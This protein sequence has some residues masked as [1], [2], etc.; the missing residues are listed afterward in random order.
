MAYQLHILPAEAFRNDAA[1]RLAVEETDDVRVSGKPAAVTHASDVE[2]KIAGSDLGAEIFYSADARWI[3]A[4]FWTGSKASI[5]ARFEPGDQND[6][7][8]RVVSALASRL[9]GMIVGDDGEIYDIATGEI[10][11]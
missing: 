4:L 1:W 11:A 9:Q 6:P 2:I 10:V 5:N 7:A 3:R 8:W